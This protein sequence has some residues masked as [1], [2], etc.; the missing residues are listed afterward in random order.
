M[1]VIIN[2]QFTVMNQ[3]Y[4]IYIGHSWSAGS[5]GVIAALGLILC[6]KV[7]AYC[8]HFF[9]RYEMKLT[10]S[11]FLSSVALAFI[12]LTSVFFLSAAI[13]MVWCSFLAAVIFF[14]EATVAFWWIPR[15]IRE[16]ELEIK[17]ASLTR[18]PSSGS[19]KEHSV[20]TVTESAKDRNT[21][22]HDDTI[23]HIVHR[24]STG[25]NGNCVT[26]LKT[27]R[28]SHKLHQVLS[29][30]R[31]FK[32]FMQHLA[33]EFSTESLLCF[34]EI[35]QYKYA[36]KKR[37][38]RINDT[39]VTDEMNVAIGCPLH[40]IVPMSLIIK[41]GFEYDL[42]K[43][44]HNDDPSKLINEAKKVCLKLYN[45]YISVGSELEVNISYEM[46]NLLI[47]LMN[48]KSFFME[49]NINANELFCIFDKVATCMFTLMHGSFRRFRQTPQFDIACK[50]V[51]KYL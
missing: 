9:I 42:S 43:Y 35:I 23:N 13:V 17:L 12:S 18:Y 21:L 27:K 25:A 31:S 8:D 38:D 34:V 44:K 1:S 29:N 32:I 41:Q 36:M 5:A 19:S 14:T 20:Q 33:Q 39:Y 10:A 6:W 46:R 47:D 11:V 49:S 16:E 37:F 7:P 50:E 24:L 40:E 26:G 51:D 4:F 3:H 2:Y 48:S 28:S 15:K 30:A 45:K 22:Q